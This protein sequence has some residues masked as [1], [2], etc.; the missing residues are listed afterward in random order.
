MEQKIKD[1]RLEVVVRGVRRGLFEYFFRD[2]EA[3]IDE[4]GKAI[5]NIVAE[6]ESDC[7]GARNGDNKERG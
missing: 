2:V 7:G 6:I 5:K 3:S 4:I 1:E